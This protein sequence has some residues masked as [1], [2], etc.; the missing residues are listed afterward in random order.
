MLS[1]LE[2]PESES[3]AASQYIWDTTQELLGTCIKTGERG[4][5]RSSMGII[6]AAHLMVLVK[7]S[8]VGLNAADRDPALQIWGQIATDRLYLGIGREDCCQAQERGCT[9]RP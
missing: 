1:I 7:E 8:L 4:E 3:K 9:A 6:I 2:R 5:N